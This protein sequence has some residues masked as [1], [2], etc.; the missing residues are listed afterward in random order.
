MQLGDKI[1]DSNYFEN[2][3]EDELTAH[4][5]EEMEDHE[6]LYDALNMPLQTKPDSQ[7][8]Q[9]YNNTEDEANRQN[10]IEADPK[11]RMRISSPIRAQTIL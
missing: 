8:Y 10:K 6:N 4:K 11:E 7:A 9:T 5:H 3:Q 1:L 2:N